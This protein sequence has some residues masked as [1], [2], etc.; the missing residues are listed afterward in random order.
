MKQGLPRREVTAEGQ[1]QKC[2][3]VVTLDGEANSDPVTVN[4]HVIDLQP[5]SWVKLVEGDYATAQVAPSSHRAWQVLGIGQRHMV[6][7][8]E[9][10]GA[11]HI[12]DRI[13]EAAGNSL[14]LSSEIGLRRRGRV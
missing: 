1:S 4:E 5:Q 6:Q 11:H 9:I 2:G 8:R 12:V 10:T 13:V 7:E 3:T 14:V